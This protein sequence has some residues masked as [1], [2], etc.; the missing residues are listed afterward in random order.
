MELVVSYAGGRKVDATF[1]GFTVCTDQPKKD[2]GDETAP[3]PF[4]Y[5]LASIGTCAG[6]YVLDFCLERKIPAEGIQLI[7]RTERN[8]EIRMTSKITIEIQLPGFFPEKYKKAVVRAAELC[9]VKKH[10]QRAPEFETYVTV[11]GE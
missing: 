1:N 11:Q 2:G 4:Q 10:I 6:Y 7:L 9:S 8:E 3:E 5:F